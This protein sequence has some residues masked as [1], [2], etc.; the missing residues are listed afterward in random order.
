VKCYQDGLVNIYASLN[1]DADGFQSLKVES[2]VRSLLKIII[3]L[4]LHSVGGFQEMN[5]SASSQHRN[6]DLGNLT[7]T[8]IC[9]TSINFSFSNLPRSHLLSVAYVRSHSIDRGKHK[10]VSTTYHVLRK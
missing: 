2:S 1:I 8:K 6:F 4:K 7:L 10:I 3:L 5:Q 9:P